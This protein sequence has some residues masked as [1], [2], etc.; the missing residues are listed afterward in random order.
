[1]FVKML[2]VGHQRNKRNLEYSTMV[3]SIIVPYKIPC[4]FSVFIS[5]S[6]NYAQTTFCIQP[7][8]T[9]T[10]TFGLPKNSTV[11]IGPDQGLIKLYFKSQINVRRSNLDY[12]ILEFVADIGG[13]LGLLL[14]FSLLDITSVLK[15][16]FV[17][18]WQV[19]QARVKKDQILPII[20]EKKK[21][22][23]ELTKSSLKINKKTY[24]V[25]TVQS[26]K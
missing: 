21:P 11:G 25:Y 19:I 16:A 18:Y 4:Y 14:G 22:V 1:M 13:Y 26:Y 5:E 9:M 23:E 7:C 6:I 15:Q 20:S 10:F 8:E 12:S 24:S 2:E 17:Y 3:K